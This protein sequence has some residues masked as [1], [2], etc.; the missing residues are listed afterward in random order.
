VASLG[1][2][3]R[4]PGRTVVL[5]DVS[6]SM[7]DRLSEKSDMTRMDAAATLASVL[8]CDDLRV[9]TFSDDL[10]EVPPRRGMAGVA[11][12]RASQRHMN[13]R[14]GGALRTL[15]RIIPDRPDRLVVITDEQ[16]EDAVGPPGAERGYMINVA[17]YKNQVG[18]GKW[19]R[20][21]GFSEGV[22]RY[23]QAMEQS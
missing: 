6:G 5:V 22:I 8:P 20:L 15:E 21:D 13:T 18:Y 10:V 3:P 2:M 16:A 7:N 1:G 23:I 19:V 9:F 12:I 11:A 14:L 17:S 4:L